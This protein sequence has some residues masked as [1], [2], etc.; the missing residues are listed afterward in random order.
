MDD[1]NRVKK[2]DVLVELD[3]EPYQVQVA[4]KQA[5]VDAARANLV[6]AQSAV[7]GLVARVRSERFKLARAIEDVDNQIA[8]LRARVKAG[9]TSLRH[10][11]QVAE[12][13][14]TRLTQKPRPD[15]N[16]SILMMPV[17]DGGYFAIIIYPH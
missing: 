16:R 3:P 10:Q 14:S 1:N 8:L 12:L 13:Y 11:I 17:T 6:V 5:A 9:A 4:M 7:R 2:G 15:Q